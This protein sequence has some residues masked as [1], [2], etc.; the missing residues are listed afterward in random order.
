M[1]LK[2]LK[3][4]LFI[5]FLFTGVITSAK[6]TVKEKGFFSLFFKDSSAFLFSYSTG[7]G[8]DGLH[9]L[10]SHDGI[11]WKTINNGESMLKPTIGKYMQDPSIVQDADGTFHMVYTTGSNNSIGY[12]TS[13]DLI[14]WSEQKELPVMADEQHVLN[15][16]APELHYDK[17]SRTFQILW[18]STIPGRFDSEKTEDGLNN[19]L[20]STTTTDFKAFTKTKLVFDPEFSVSDGCI[21][22][23]KGTFYL[24]FKNDMD[25]KIQYV[26]S[27]KIKSFPSTV[28]EPISGKKFAKGP[29]AIQVGNFTYVYWEND[30]DKR[31]SAVRCK[32]IR[33][34][35]WEDVSDMIKF[36]G[37]VKQGSA[38][39]VDNETLVQLQN[40]EKGSE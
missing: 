4:T 9:L 38:F 21:L 12:S 29:T 6:P 10:Y 23:S 8:S 24:Y 7:D 20:Y 5:L 17:L 1:T 18:A 34:A 30:V 27:G 35:L 37:D 11:I 19:R 26:T 28:S 33:K 40:L 39:V 3:F 36:P 25:R 14:T 32:N 2:Y 16:S 13:K 15:S 31:V 22:K